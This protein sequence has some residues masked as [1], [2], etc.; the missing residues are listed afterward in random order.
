M[1]I[2]IKNFEDLFDKSKY[3]FITEQREEY[4]KCQKAEAEKLRIFQKK[5][6]IFSSRFSVLIIWCLIKIYYLYI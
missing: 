2:F 5:V 4:Q 3:I 1:N 6:S